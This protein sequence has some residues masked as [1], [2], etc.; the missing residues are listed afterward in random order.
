M[1]RSQTQSTTVS[2]ETP[3]SFQLSSHY[4]GTGTKED[5]F[6]IDWHEHDYENPKQWTR[7]RRWLLTLLVSFATWNVSFASSSYSAGLGPLSSDLH[8]TRILA[9]LGISVYVLG[10]G[11]G[12]LLFAPLSELYGRRNVFLASYTPYLLFHLGGAIGK[13]IET[14][15]ITRFLAGVA[16]SSPLT[17]AGGQISDMWSPQDRTLATMIYSL[18]TFFGPVSGP[19]VGGFVAESF[20]HGWR[21]NFWIMFG[22]SALVVLISF[23]K[24]PETYPPLLLKRR[25]RR[26]QA[27]S[28][29]TKYYSSI[30][31]QLKSTSAREM[32]LTNL[33]RPFLFLLTEPTILLTSLYV[34]IAYATLY[35]QFV[36]YPIVYG[37]HRHFTS[38]EIGLTFLGIMVGQ[39]IALISSPVQSRYYRKEIRRWGR[40]VPEKR[41]HSAMVGAIALPVGMFW[42]AWT[43][44]PTIP[45]ILSILS[46]IPF[47]LGT[48]LIMTTLNAYIMDTYSVYCASALAAIVFVRSILA[49]A[50]PLFSSVM[51]AKLGDEWASSVFAFV[52][53][54]GVPVPFL[55]YRYGGWIRSKSPYALHTEDDDNGAAGHGQGAVTRIEQTQR[56]SAAGDDEKKGEDEG[57]KERSRFKQTVSVDRL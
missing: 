14:V 23:F 50:F 55:F 38:G 9:D 51:F 19:I 53:V 32:F 12:P 57:E 47:G 8:T 34:G 40:V 41:L 48:I 15:I 54:A 44:R 35:A 21:I 37:K 36:A 39:W 46:G 20:P 3:S 52:A 5:P 10:F 27:E 16:G 1:S 31:E 24:L 26:L 43:S 13:N 17:N 42:F 49:A 29:N 33:K 6:I 4:T 45:A 2:S 7:L 30:H 28:G 56:S 22:L 18:C 11:L 25:A